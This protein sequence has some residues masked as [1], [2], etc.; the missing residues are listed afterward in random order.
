VSYIYKAKHKCRLC[1]K[2]YESGSTTGDRDIV[3]QSMAE[4][5]VGIGTMPQAPTLNDVHYCENGNIGCA[6]FLGWQREE[7]EDETFSY[8]EIPF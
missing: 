4:L 8:G 6:D 2:V 5:I 3:N 7:K 1:G